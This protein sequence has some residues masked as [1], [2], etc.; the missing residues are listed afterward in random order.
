MIRF[1]LAAAI[2]SVSFGLSAAPLLAQTTETTSVPVQTDDLNLRSGAGQKTLEHRLKLAADKACGSS[3]DRR[4]LTSQAAEQRCRDEVRRSGTAQAGTIV[5][6]QEARERAERAALLA[7]ASPPHRAAARRSR[8]R[9]HVQ[10]RRVR[11]AAHRRVATHARPAGR[12]A[13]R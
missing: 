4:D 3:T 12:P 8:A 2:A 10:H 6:R 9:R 11:H 7:Q 5:A 1:A 13:S